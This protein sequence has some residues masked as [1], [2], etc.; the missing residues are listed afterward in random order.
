MK[1]MGETLPVGE[2]S[3]AGVK[4]VEEEGEEEEMEE[5]KSGGA[6][7]V[8]E[9]EAEISGPPPECKAEDMQKLED[10]LLKRVQQMEPTAEV[11]VTNS[12]EEEKKKEQNEDAGKKA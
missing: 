4:V 12:G 10:E 2:E 5:Q 6:K 3:V 9:G 1:Q 8:L 11:Q 7:Q